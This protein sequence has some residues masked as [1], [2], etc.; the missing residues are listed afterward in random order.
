MTIQTAHIKISHESE[1]AE[2][3]TSYRIYILHCICLSKRLL[4]CKSEMV[5]LTEAKVLLCITSFFVVQY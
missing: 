2:S 5:S 3:K 4:L 1:L